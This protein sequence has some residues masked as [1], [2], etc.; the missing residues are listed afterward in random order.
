MKEPSKLD[1]YRSNCLEL[2]FVSGA[3]K[4]NDSEMKLMDKDYEW[5]FD[6]VL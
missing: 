4:F 2:G 1:K 5:W 3:E 6:S